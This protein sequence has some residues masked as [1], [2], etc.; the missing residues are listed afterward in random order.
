MRRAKEWLR[1]NRV[2]GAAKI[3][4]PS[5]SVTHQWMKAAFIAST[6]AA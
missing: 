6:A 5:I 2:R 3:F 4:S 1:Y